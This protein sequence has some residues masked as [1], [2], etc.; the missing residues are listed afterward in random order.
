MVFA[1]LCSGSVRCEHVH[2]GG[3]SSLDEMFARMSRGGGRGNSD[4]GY[5]GTGRIDDDGD[6]DDS[7]QRMLG[8][9]R[10][11]SQLDSKHGWKR[12]WM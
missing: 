8:G 5:G 11:S 12:S 9:A 7:R 3:A 6:E 10:E 2:A 4:G 1:R